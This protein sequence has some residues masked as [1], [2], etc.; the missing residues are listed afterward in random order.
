MVVSP[1]I[2]KVSKQLDGFALNGRQVW[3][4][5][6]KK[7]DGKSRT[8]KVF[9][10]DYSPKE[11]NIS[12]LSKN[13]EILEEFKSGINIREFFRT[14][15][16][17]FNV[18]YQNRLGELIGP[19]CII[20]FAFGIISLYQLKKHYEVFLLITFIGFNLAGPIFHNVAIRHIISIAPIIFLISGVG[21]GYLVSIFSGTIDQPTLQKRLIPIIIIF[22]TVSAWVIPLRNTF[23]PKQENHEYSP[24]E[25]SAPI[26]IIKKISENELGRAP[27]IAAERGYLA[28]FSNGNQFYLPFTIYEK[29]VTYCELNN[30]DF[31]YLNHHRV[32]SKKYPFYEHFQKKGVSDFDT[33]YSGFDFHGR[34]VSLFRYK[35]PQNT[36]QK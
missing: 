14:I 23:K 31:F 33:I 36:V 29:F 5:V 13:S 34:E 10:L 22:I 12:Y 19:L 16:R 7:A 27:N 26:S 20:F 35:N 6:Y 11:V 9:G 18:L 30:V 15:L 32:K 17:E 2:Y 4:A 25:L 28:Y 24:V 21:V 1:Q 3:S 8:E